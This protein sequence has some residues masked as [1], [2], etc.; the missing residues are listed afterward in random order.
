MV[1]ERARVPEPDYI[2]GANMD[3]FQKVR[4]AWEEDYNERVASQ[5]RSILNT[6]QIS[7]Y[8]EYQQA[9]KDMRAQFGALMPAGPRRAIRGVAGGNVTFM[10]AAPAGGVALSA[11]FV[12]IAAPPEADQ[13]K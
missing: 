5:A 3:E 8:T 9:Q 11:D 12:N 10:S 1:E 2:D 6:E 4:T 7:A 13:K